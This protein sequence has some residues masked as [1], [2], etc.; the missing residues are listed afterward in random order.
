VQVPEIQNLLA[1]GERIVWSGQPRSGLALRGSDAL[2]IPFSL[3]WGGFAIF[4]EYSVF[5]TGAPL[6]FRLWG[7]PFVLVGL[8]LIFGRF[9][10]DAWIRQKTYYA[11]TEERALIVSGLF[12]RQTTT[13]D[14]AT[15][16]N[17]SLSEGSD[18]E[19]TISFGSQTTPKSPFS[20][21]SGWPGA[22]AQSGSQFDLIR[23]A[24]AVFAMIRDAQRSRS[25]KDV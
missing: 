17:V 3:M 8:Y 2:A 23:N 24:K 12:S 10:V 13:L 16:S 9:F 1:P 5:N 11:L 21:M 19:G 22:S 18:G 7:V 6:F 25:P 15:I 4:W 14:L 20:G